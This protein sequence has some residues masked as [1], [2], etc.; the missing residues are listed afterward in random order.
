M[1][2]ISLFLP[3][4]HRFLPFPLRDSLHTAMKITK[5]NINN[6]K[7]AILTV[8]LAVGLGTLLSAL[9]GYDAK[10][11]WQVS[12]LNYRIMQPDDP[13]NLQKLS[14]RHEP[15][16]V[17]TD[18]ADF[19]SGDVSQETAEGTVEKPWAELAM[20]TSVEIRNLQ[21]VEVE[22]EEEDSPSAGEMTLKCVN[23]DSVIYIRTAV[24]RDEAGERITPEYYLGRT[25]DVKG[26]VDKFYDTYQILV[27]TSKHITIHE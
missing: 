25:I 4:N 14:E 8:I 9:L 24:L 7:N 3:N 26:F 2:E 20:G 10:Q 11:V 6:R 16:W 18:P 12:D 22:A 5:W 27:F 21:V 13:G 17:L 23:G 15:G 19:A 1:E